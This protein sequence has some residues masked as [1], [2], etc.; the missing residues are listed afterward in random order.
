MTPQAM[1]K[2]REKYRAAISPSYSGWLHM[3][4][5]LLV[6]VSVI[7]YCLLN[8]DNASW[9]EWTIFP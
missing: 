5:V 1:E 8:S 4:F 7:V 3:V 6:G 2:F 9:R